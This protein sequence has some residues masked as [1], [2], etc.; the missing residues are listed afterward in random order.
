MDYTVERVSEG[1]RIERGGGAQGERQRQ[2]EKPPRK[3]GRQDSVCISD[4]AR[5]RLADHPEEI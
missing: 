1:V 2:R 3:G 4:E 5:R